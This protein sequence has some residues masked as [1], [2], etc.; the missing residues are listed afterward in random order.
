M[1]KKKAL[2]LVADDYDDAA[3]IVAALIEHSTPYEAVWAKDGKAAL[4]LALQA[5]P[6][7]AVLDVDMPHIGG[8]E[9]ARALRLAFQD[10]A[11]LLIAA[12]G[13]AIEEAVHSEMF[14]VV[15]RKPVPFDALADLLRR[16]MPV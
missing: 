5:R 16:L 9:L 15:L 1:L 2:V 8:I 7:A 12:T 3:P 10:R 14:D 6:D 11:P 4:D 13:G